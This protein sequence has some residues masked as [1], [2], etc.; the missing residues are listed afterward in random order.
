MIT[1]SELEFLRERASEIL[2]RKHRI[3]VLEHIEEKKI[4]IQYRRENND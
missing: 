1:D 4:K 3:K 2:W